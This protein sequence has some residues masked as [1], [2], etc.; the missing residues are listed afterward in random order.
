MLKVIFSIFNVCGDFSNNATPVL[1]VYPLSTSVRCC[2]T[3]LPWTYPAACPGPSTPGAATPVVETLD[4][5]EEEALASFEDDSSD[6]DEGPIEPVE[7]QPATAQLPTAAPA[8]ASARTPRVRK[9]YDR[10][11]IASVLARWA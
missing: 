5:A 7:E 9:L 11:A 1:Q 8:P 2:T 6:E 4:P 10:H 3:R